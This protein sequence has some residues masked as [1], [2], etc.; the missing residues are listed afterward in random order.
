MSRR[1]SETW[2]H[3]SSTSYDSLLGC[4]R[5]A[6]VFLAVWE[7]RMTFWM[8]FAERLVISCWCDTCWIVLTKTFCVPCVRRAAPNDLRRSEG[9][10]ICC[11][12]LT[13]SCRSCPRRSGVGVKRESMSGDPVASKRVGIMKCQA[14]L[15]AAACRCTAE[16]TPSP[17]IRSGR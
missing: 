5:C 9:V 6:P 17:P 13:C 15:G 12:S 1:A 14:V 7:M 2:K 4:C 10:S 16:P 11:D 3:L 8:L